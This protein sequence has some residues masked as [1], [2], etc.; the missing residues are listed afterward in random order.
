MNVSNGALW[1]A[2]GTHGNGYFLERK[3]LEQ[4]WG[5]TDQNSWQGALDGLL[6]GKGVRGLWEFVLEIRSSLSQQFGG[7]G[8]S[9]TVAGD[10]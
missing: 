8:R 10:G 6:K 4:W 2:M 3:S 7:A 9:G 5:V 1:N